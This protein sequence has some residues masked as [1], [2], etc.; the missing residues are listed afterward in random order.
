MKFD[1]LLIMSFVNDPITGIKQLRNGQLQTIKLRNP[2]DHYSS[3]VMETTGK[4]KRLRD[5]SDTIGFMLDVGIFTNWSFKGTRGVDRLIMGSQAVIV[6]KG[7]GGTINFGRDNVR[8]VFKFTNTI[9]VKRISAIFGRPVSRYNHL[10][11]VTINNFGRRDRIV[12][13]GTAYGLED[14]QA[15]GTLPGIEASR[16]KVNL[17]RG[18]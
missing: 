15:D 7:R 9:N 2:V 1:L 10:A 11:G 8:D 6:T 16:L 13:Q 12:I 3:F 5:G 17:Q 14:V 18:L 4:S